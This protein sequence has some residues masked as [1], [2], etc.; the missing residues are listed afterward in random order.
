MDLIS[1][2]YILTESGEL[3]LQPGSYTE[4]PDFTQQAQ[5]TEQSEENTEAQ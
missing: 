4:M 5:V 2:T 3:E 1:G